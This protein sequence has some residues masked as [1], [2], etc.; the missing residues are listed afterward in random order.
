MLLGGHVQVLLVNVVTRLIGVLATG[1][2]RLAVVRG[3]ALLVG[4]TV[5]CDEVVAAV[6]DTCRDPITLM[7]SSG[8]PD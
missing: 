4:G 2:G 7:Q 8:F 5:F 1:H 6:D 3:Y